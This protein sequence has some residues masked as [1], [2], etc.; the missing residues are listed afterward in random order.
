[1]RHAV[2]DVLL[3]FVSCVIQVAVGM[4]ES[5]RSLVASLNSEELI[6]LEDVLTPVPLSLDIVQASYGHLKVGLF[7]ACELVGL[8]HISI[9]RCINS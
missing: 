9:K 6:V 5:V 1:M 8:C 2:Q 7:T 4:I 3:N